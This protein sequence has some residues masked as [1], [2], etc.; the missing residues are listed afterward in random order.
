ML[1]GSE[2]VG[3][4]AKTR[5]VDRPVSRHQKKTINQ[6]LDDSTWPAPIKDTLP[7]V[8]LC[9]FVFIQTNH[10]I[11]CTFTA[12]FYIHVPTVVMVCTL[13]ITA[14]VQLEHLLTMTARGS[15]FQPFHAPGHMNACYLVKAYFIADWTAEK[16]FTRVL[17]GAGQQ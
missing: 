4:V 1:A 15:V 13:P 2:S 10:C 6:S 14:P 17:S 7:S 8:G 12:P 16:S 3:I 11:Q 5:Q 9:S